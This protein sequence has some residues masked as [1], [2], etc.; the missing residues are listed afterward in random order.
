[1]ADPRSRLMRQPDPE[2]Q[3][4][5]DPASTASRLADPARVQPARLG[6]TATDPHSL[7]QIDDQLRRAPHV[8]APRTLA[9]RIM[10]QLAAQMADGVMVGNTRLSGLA[11]AIALALVTATLLPLLAVAGLFLINTLTSAALLSA[12]LAGLAILLAAIANALAAIATGAQAVMTAY[13]EAPLA[14]VVIPAGALWLLRVRSRT[15]RDARAARL[16]T[17]PPAVPPVGD[18]PAAHL[19]DRIE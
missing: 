15:R 16:Q 17:H 2:P 9:T 8:P 5:A 7:R 18:P 10:T 3:P 6:K 4:D 1:M 19:S 13:P 12:V 14:L 11:L